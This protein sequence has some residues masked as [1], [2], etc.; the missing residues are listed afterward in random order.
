MQR[1]N[2]FFNSANIY[3]NIFIFQTSQ[4]FIDVVVNNIARRTKNIEYHEPNDKIIDNMIPP[5][6]NSSSLIAIARIIIVK[7]RKKPIK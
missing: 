1:Y 4:S 3:L 5:T 6:V 2:Q 7:A